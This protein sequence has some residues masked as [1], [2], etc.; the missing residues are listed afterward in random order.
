MEKDSELSLLSLL[1]D[2]GGD[3]IRR[4]R[5]RCTDGNNQLAGVEVLLGKDAFRFDRKNDDAMRRFRNAEL[6]TQG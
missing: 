5:R 2:R 6:L 3:V 1:G 4:G